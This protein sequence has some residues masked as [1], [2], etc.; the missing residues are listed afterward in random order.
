[1]RI[2]GSL[3]RARACTIVT[4]PNEHDVLI[5]ASWAYTVRIDKPNP[6][7]ARMLKQAIGGPEGEMRV[8]TQYMFQGFGCPSLNGKGEF[9]LHEPPRRSARTPSCSPPRRRSMPGATRPR[10]TA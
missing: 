7:F 5:I 3:A 4:L 8:M 10:L 9:S 6:A 2:H 1:M